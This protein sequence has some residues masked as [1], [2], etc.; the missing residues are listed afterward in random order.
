M[1][2]IFLFKKDK[3]KNINIKYKNINFSVKYFDMCLFQ[4]HDLQ[5]EILLKPNHLHELFFINIFPLDILN[6]KEIN[7]N[8]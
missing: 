4:L 6:S 7:R 1:L 2:N 5:Y 8:H 3:N